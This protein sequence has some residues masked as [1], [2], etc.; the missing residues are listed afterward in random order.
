MSN[1]N[2]AINN[3]N[4]FSVL[5][6]D[7]EDSDDEED[8][9][10]DLEHEMMREIDE[11]EKTI[12]YLQEKIENLEQVNTRREDQLAQGERGMKSI[13]ERVKELEVEKR[14]LENYMGRLEKY[15]VEREKEHM[16][17]V[18]KLLRRNNVLFWMVHL[19][20]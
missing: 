14:R 8:S 5:S 4:R 6:E 10:H 15:I 13:N 7:D 19:Q 11:C 18:D 20:Y 3:N 1:D 16:K 2:I 17:I 12:H 9:G